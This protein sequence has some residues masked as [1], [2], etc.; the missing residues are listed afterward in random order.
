MKEIFNILSSISENICQTTS[1]ADELCVLRSNLNP[2]LKIKKSSK[3][4]SEN[5]LNESNSGRQFNE[6]D[7]NDDEKIEL[8]AYQI[9]ELEVKDC[10]DDNLGLLTQI[11]KTFQNVCFNVIPWNCIKCGIRSNLVNV[12]ENTA[13]QFAWKHKDLD[14]LLKLFSDVRRDNNIKKVTDL[15]F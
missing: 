2:D 9:D 3:A 1:T 5:L 8:E 6:N 10:D 13:S 4:L 15:L 12:N 14:L 7:N 11:R